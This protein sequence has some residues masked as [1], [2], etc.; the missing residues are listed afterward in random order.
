MG[1]RNASASALGWDF[2]ANAAILLMLENIKDA[3]RVRV[4]GE[5]ED[6]EITLNDKTKIYSQA[7]SVAKPDDYSHVIEKLSAALETLNLDAKNG[8]GSLFTY[9]TNSPNP[10]N[11][12]KTMSYFNGRT[13]L[14]FD[15]LPDKAQE[16]INELMEKEGFDS[17]DTSKMDIRVIPFHGRDPKNKYKWIQE[18]INE[19]LVELEMPTEGI[20]TRIL[21]IWQRDFFQNATQPDTSITISKSKMMWPLIVLIIDKAAAND[22]KK[23][24]DDDEISEIERKYRSII[25]HNT[26]LYEFVT[27]IVT[28][29]RKSKLSAKEFV[30][31]N[32]KNYMDVIESVSAEES[33]KQTL[34]KIIL[35]KILIQK[36]YISDIKKGVN[37]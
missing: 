14:Y 12:Q 15:E 26:M 35:Y 5:D 21:E 4:E 18:S 8:D 24:F 3:D 19:L 33:T 37:L 2:Q 31:L 1:E 23:D 22:Y 6:I 13:H 28:D 10:F 36:Q 25:N 27:K 34:M 7:K 11:N 17:L 32:W 30:N 20:G 29:H 16:K 9:T